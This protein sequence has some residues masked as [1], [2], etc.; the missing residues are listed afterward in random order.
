MEKDIE[1]NKYLVSFLEYL[2]YQKNYS[3][4]TI[5]SYKNDIVEYL[6]YISREA[7]DFKD[8]EYGDIRFYLMYLKE[9]KNENNFQK[10]VDISK[11]VVYNKITS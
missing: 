4:Y 8:I 7:L 10:R 5:I 6:E 1:N 2:K 9:E 3:D 11:F